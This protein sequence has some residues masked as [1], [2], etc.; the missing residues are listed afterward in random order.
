MRNLL[1]IV[2]EGSGNVHDEQIAAIGQ[3]IADQ[4]E[5][6]DAESKLSTDA[7]I[8]IAQKMG[9]SLTPETLMQM[10]EEGKLDSVIKKVTP[11]EIVFKGQKDIPGE[12]IDVDKAK[13]VVKKMAKRT[14]K[15]HIKQSEK[16][17]G[18]E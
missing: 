4:T 9:L 12:E 16:L 10:K 6:A 3:L 1:N 18:L 2:T 11:E 8:K 17:P 7:F 14:A 15:K 13:E 5:D